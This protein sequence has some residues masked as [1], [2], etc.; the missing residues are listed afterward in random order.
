[1]PINSKRAKTCLFHCTLSTPKSEL[2]SR[3]DI[4]H[5]FFLT[6]LSTNYVSGIEL[7]TKD[8]E[9]KKQSSISV[10]EDNILE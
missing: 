6:L 4:Q 8:K 9:I 3:V 1:M 2:G 5:I 7:G 10:W